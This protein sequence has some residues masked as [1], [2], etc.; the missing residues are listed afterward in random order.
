[1]KNHATNPKA[2][3]IRRHGEARLARQEKA[4]QPTDHEL[5]VLSTY[6]E[7]G[8]AKE[9]AYRLGLAERTVEWHL[10]N[11]RAKAGT[12]TIAQAIWVLRRR[13]GASRNTG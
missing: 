1:M 5:R 6:I 12:P 10:A 2:Q 4:K 13:L 11:I 9:A 8:S 7:A 3:R